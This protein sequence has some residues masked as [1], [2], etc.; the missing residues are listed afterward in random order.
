MSWQDLMDTVEM[1]VEK[2]PPW[3]KESLRFRNGRPAR[4]FSE[5]FEALHSDTIIF[6]KPSRQDA[7]RFEAKNAKILVA[8]MRKLKKLIE[9]HKILPSH[10]AKVDET[11]FSP[12]T[13]RKY[14][15]QKK[16]LARRGVTPLLPNPSFENGN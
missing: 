8:H 7:K 4:R 10:I 9:F 16:V 6:R 2:F 15:N 11:G 13:E 1:L 12:S 3:R 14:G 5:L